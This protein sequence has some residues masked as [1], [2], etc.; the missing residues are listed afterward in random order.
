MLDSIEAAQADCTV[1]QTFENRHSLNCFGAL[2]FW[3]GNLVGSGL[4]LLDYLKEVFVVF[5]KFLVVFG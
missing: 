5:L 2:F 3:N 4:V 1:E